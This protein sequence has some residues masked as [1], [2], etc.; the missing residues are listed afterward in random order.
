MKD[1]VNIKITGRHIEPGAKTNN[2]DSEP[3]ETTGYGVYK[4]MAGNEYIRY[5][6]F[7]EGEQE[8]ITCIIKISGDTVE[9]TRK[10]SATSS[11]TFVPD[12][13][14]VTSYA[15][16]YGNIDMGVFSKRVDIERSQDLIKVAVD[17]E[18]EVNNE[19][20]SESNVIIEITSLEG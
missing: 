7:D 1:K 9:T 6:E 3:I 19:K 20:V 5:E 8:K 13:K 17:Y 16:P 4:V 12:K 15:T 2:D 11:M 14:I 18:L 10:G